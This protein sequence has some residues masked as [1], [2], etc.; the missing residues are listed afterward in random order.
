MATNERLTAFN[1]N[2]IDIKIMSG[3]R[4]ISTPTT[5]SVK[6][7]ALT[8]KYADNGT[9]HIFLLPTSVCFPQY[10]C[11]QDGNNNQQACYLKGKDKAMEEGQAKGLGIALCSNDMRETIRAPVAVGSRINR[12][13]P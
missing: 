13:F 1:I 10:H 9:W 7:R 12:R 2:S 5:P 6:I 3:L 4:R 11:S 8:I